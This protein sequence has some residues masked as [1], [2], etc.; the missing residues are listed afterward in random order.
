M[1]VVKV[2]SGHVSQETAYV[3]EDYP[4]GFTLRCQIRFWIETNGKKG[5]RVVSQTSNPKRPGLVWNKPK[6]STYSAVRVLFVDSGVAPRHPRG[7][8]LMT[9]AT[10]DELEQRIANGE[11]ISS[12]DQMNQEYFDD[13]VNLNRGIETWDP[14]AEPAHT[15]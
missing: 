8:D 2:L 3:V 9:E 7:G 13:L 1:A 15:R 4:Y 11:R 10:A 6:A 12:R 14:H 5:S